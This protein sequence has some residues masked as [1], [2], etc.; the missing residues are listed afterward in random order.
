[1]AYHES[2]DFG[3]FDI[4]ALILEGTF[5]FFGELMVDLVNLVEYTVLKIVVYCQCQGRVYHGICC[6]VEPYRIKVSI[7]YDGK[8]GRVFPARR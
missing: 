3:K 1:M 2:K 5:A 4:V 6:C 8:L 7:E